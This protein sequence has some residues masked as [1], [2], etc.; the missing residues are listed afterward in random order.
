MFCLETLNY[1]NE[2]APRIIGASIY[3]AVCALE[4][5]EAGAD[6]IVAWHAEDGVYEEDECAGCG[7]PIGPD[8]PSGSYKDG[9]R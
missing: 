6:A 9:D 8:A 5:E 3:H 2:R 4:L 1:V 7:G